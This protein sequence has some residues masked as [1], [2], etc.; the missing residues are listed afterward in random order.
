MKIFFLL[1]QETILE[2]ILLVNAAMQSF[3]QS[4]HCQSSGNA[5][6]DVNEFL[7]ELQQLYSALD[8]RSVYSLYIHYFIVLFYLFDVSSD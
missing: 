7:D 8:S 1:F 4:N 3:C 5:V 6:G 2:H